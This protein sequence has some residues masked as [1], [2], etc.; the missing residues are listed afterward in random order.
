MKFDKKLSLELDRALSA[1]ESENFARHE[2][3][4][5]WKRNL[6]QRIFEQEEKNDSTRGDQP[7]KRRTT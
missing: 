2:L 4:K 7:N 1:L 6:E 5:I 3:G